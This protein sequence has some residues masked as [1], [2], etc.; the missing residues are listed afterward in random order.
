MAPPEVVPVPRVK[1]I[2]V[3][4]LKTVN[5]ESN[6]FP[7]GIPR[8]IKA[9]VPRICTPG[10]D[11]F[12]LPKVIP[13]IAER[14]ISVQLPEVILAKD[15]GVKD[16]NPES[17]MSFKQLQGLKSNNIGANI[18]QDKK[19]NLW[20]GT[21]GG[22]VTKYDGRSFTHY[23]TAQGLSSESVEY[24]LED[25]KGNLWFGTGNG[26]INKYDGKS[27]THYSIGYNSGG[28]IIEDKSGNLW[29]SASGGLIKFDGKSFT[30]YSTAQGLSTN[31]V[32]VIF[33]DKRGNLWFDTNGEGLTKYDG[34]SFTHYTSAQG[35][36]S[37]LIT[38]FF[39]DKNGILWIGTLDAGLN[40]Y[41][42]KS[43]TYYTTAQGL[44]S[45]YVGMILEDKSDNLWICTGKGINRY[46]GKSFTHFGID[47]GLSN[48][49]RSIL[50]DKSGNI[51]IGTS[52]EGLNKY[53][54]NSFT[55]YS[56]AQG[57]NSGIGSI[58]R[59]GSISED[60]SA[61]LWFSIADGVSKYDGK[62]F[63]YFGID[64]G[65]RSNVTS[66]LEDKSDNLWFATQGAGLYKYDGKSFTNYT[67]AQGLSTNF[68]SYIFEDKSGNLWIGTCCRG[69]TGWLGWGVVKYDG[70]SFTNYAAA[71]GLT[72]RN[73]TCISEDKSGNLWFGT[74]GEGVIKYD[75]RSFTKYS[76]ANGLNDSTVLSIL[77]DKR[78][79]LW[80]GTGSG[81][82]NKFDGKSFTQYTTAQGLSN[83][84]VTGILEDKIGDIWFGTHNG[85]SRMQLS[86]QTL[87]EKGNITNN[88]GSSLFKNY[89]FSDGFLGVGTNSLCQDSTGNIWVGTNDRLTCFHPEGDLPDTIPPGIQL[90][91]ISLFNENINWLDLERKKDT[92]QLLGNGV[93]LHDFKFSGLSKWSYIP[94]QLELV[95]NN[96]YITFQFIGITTNRPSEVKYQYLLEG[97]DKNWS[98]ITDKPEASYSNLPNGNYTFRVKAVNSEGYWSNEFTYDF[99]ILP[100]W[101]KTNWFRILAG[102]ALLV[103]LY[104]IYRW[105]T[106]ALRRQK[107]I[108]EQTVKERTAEVV[109]EKAQVESTLQELKSTQAQLIQSEKMA[110]L[111]EL[112]AGIAHE[113]QNPLNFVNN[114]SE[115]NSELIA[116]MKNELLTG[117]KDEAIS[118]ANDIEEN[119]QKIKH[120]GRRADGIVK[121]MLQHSR[122]STGKKEPTDINA[123]ADEYLRLSFHGLR[124][125]DRSF[126]ATLKTEFDRNIGEINIARQ[127]I[128]RVL[129]NLYNNAFYAVTEKNNSTGSVSPGYEPTVS[130]RTRRIN[131][132]IEIS[133][134]DNGNGIPQ[135]VL[136]KIY[137]PFFTTKPTGQGTGLGLSLCYDIVKAHG[138]EMKVNTKE[139]ACAE[140]IIQLPV[141]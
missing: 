130:V 33:E 9:G 41:D 52:G 109:E 35:L 81:G 5:L 30:I 117:N 104:V 16:N 123:L 119:E 51:W 139:G 121:S 7:V 32:W 37:D 94:E 1:S 23:S 18:I 88:S 90:T 62:S 71:Q 140:F 102:I 111:G 43:F 127:D 58:S 4:K 98:S 72:D 13:A 28:N 44:S 115:L 73:I 107:R 124:A 54:G 24:V 19:G 108:L 79:N 100:P 92:S 25:K 38:S 87:D 126:N 63:T 134:E 82:V 34:K 15:P 78:N 97:L 114:F 29:F 116:E 84:T 17:F 101:W 20:F 57:L 3:G 93:R 26:D 74:G 14:G 65:L 61:N 136:D 132:R 141:V 122:S 45:D 76:I 22:G 27:F 59:I 137:Q 135:K 12:K 47:Q 80:F 66:F 129:L 75:G 77:E 68:L 56:T 113:I 118:I 55:H 133:V 131:D 91:G 83:N 46:D 64:Q 138:G 105:R 42:G 53:A 99:T 120:H 69:V 110:S 103:L 6:V 96:N 89:L 36:S 48:N 85:I 31:A 95:Y 70:K 60:K 2:A 11:T 128:G 8:I 106:A 112:T 67:R 50:E 49:V 125:K 39:E 86:K 21:G 40:K 10:Q